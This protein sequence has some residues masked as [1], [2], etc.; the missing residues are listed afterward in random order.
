M[1]VHAVAGVLLSLF[2]F[3]LPERAAAE[4]LWAPLHCC[5]SCLL[6]QEFLQVLTVCLQRQRVNMQQ[7]RLC[8]Q[9]SCQAVRLTHKSRELGLSRQEPH[10]LRACKTKW[11][12]TQEG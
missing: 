9:H 3:H 1:Q 5:C 12:R 8:C 7:R 4:D 11:G 2:V 6:A 10:Q